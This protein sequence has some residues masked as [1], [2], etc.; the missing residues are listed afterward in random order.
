MTAARY[1]LGLLLAL[2]G[3]AASAQGLDEARALYRQG[4]FIE[5]AAAAGAV[6]TPPALALAARALL[7]EAAYVAP[8]EKAQAI[9]IRANELAGTALARN[10]DTIEALLQK[11]VAQ[12]YLARLEGPVAAHFAGRATGARRLIDHALELAPDNPWAHALLGGWHGEIICRAGRFFGRT[13]YGASQKEMRRQ[14]ALARRLLP[15]N[16]VLAFEYAKALVCRRAVKT[17][18]EARA[19]LAVALAA[20]PQNAF[21]ALVIACARRLD[22]ALAAPGARR[23]R[24]VLREIEP[25]LP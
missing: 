13:F 23:V 2:S 10:P 11:A 12:G 4:R 19:A 24:A 22:A 16:P 3:F 7:V 25:F 20:K 14:F 18:A 17:R 1:A 6:G 8:P 9:L 15:G 5:A 21:E